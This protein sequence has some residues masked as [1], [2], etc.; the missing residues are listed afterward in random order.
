MSCVVRGCGEHTTKKAILC[1]KHWD[2]IPKHLQQDIRKGTEKGQH[3]LRANPSREW[4]GAI[5][6]HVGDVKNLVVKVDAQ[7]NK[8]SRKIQSKPEEVPV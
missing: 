7:T 1:K 3:A 8:I 4:L 5:S 6:K 2:T